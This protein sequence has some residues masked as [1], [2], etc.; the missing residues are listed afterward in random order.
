MYLLNTQVIDGDCCTGSCIEHPDD[1]IE[2]VGAS[3][4]FC[5]PCDP[6]KVV[7]YQMVYN[8]ALCVALYAECAGFNE[9]ANKTNT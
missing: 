5:D 4:L 8:C 1:D 9:Q 7:L 3:L 6:T 2:A